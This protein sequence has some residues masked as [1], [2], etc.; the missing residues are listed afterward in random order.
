MRTT[1]FSLSQ[2]ILGN[3]KTKTKLILLLIITNIL[4]GNVIKADHLL[5]LLPDTCCQEIIYI[6]LTYLI[7]SFYSKRLIFFSVFPDSAILIFVL[8]PLP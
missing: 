3:F 6:S 4:M 5:C 8:L 2:R 1:Y 7:D